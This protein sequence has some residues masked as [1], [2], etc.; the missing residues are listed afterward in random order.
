MLNVIRNQDGRV[1]RSSRSQRG[2]R[3]YVGS[4]SIKTLA[5]NELADSSGKLC[6]L[7]VNGSSFEMNWASFDVLRSSLLR[8]RNCYDAPLLVNGNAAGKV[9]KDNETLINYGRESVK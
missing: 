1:I 2:I 4:H 3:E 5:I 6:I 9:S 8:W 7:F